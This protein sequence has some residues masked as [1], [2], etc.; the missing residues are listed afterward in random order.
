MTGQKSHHILGTGVGASLKKPERLRARERNICRKFQQGSVKHQ[1]HYAN[2]FITGLS[3]G[4]RSTNIRKIAQ[5]AAQTE[6]RKL[7]RPIS[8]TPEVMGVMMTRWHIASHNMTTSAVTS[9]SFQ[10]SGWRSARSEIRM[11]LKV[12]ILGL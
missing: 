11:D 7:E 2:R 9:S 10:S 5:T 3:E 4:K 6:T 8:I 1:E 12:W